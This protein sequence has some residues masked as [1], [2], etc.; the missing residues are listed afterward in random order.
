MIRQGDSR[1]APASP[2]PEN[3]LPLCEFH[4]DRYNIFR[5]SSPVKGILY[6]P[7]QKFRSWIVPTGRPRTFDVDE[8]LEIALKVFWRK[9]Y[10]GTS[11]D[12]LTGAMGINRPSLYCAFGNKEQLFRKALD[13]YLG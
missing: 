8:A 2:F 10:E 1:P 7:V 12:D 9:G 3:S 6:C 5:W 4:T 13:R 11:I